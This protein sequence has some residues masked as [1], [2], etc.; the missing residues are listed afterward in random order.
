MFHI[1]SFIFSVLSNCIQ[2]KAYQKYT[3]NEDLKGLYFHGFFHHITESFQ[4]KLRFVCELPGLFVLPILPTCLWD[5]LAG[6]LCQ[7]GLLSTSPSPLVA[8]LGFLKQHYWRE[9]MHLRTPLYGKPHMAST[10]TLI[11]LLLLG[12]ENYVLVE[13]NLERLYMAVREHLDCW[14]YTWWRHWRRNDEILNF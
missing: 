8:N 11:L 9:A 10:S 6:E 1:N 2:Q 3:L 5:A 4:A 14:T 12:S 7:R 13:V